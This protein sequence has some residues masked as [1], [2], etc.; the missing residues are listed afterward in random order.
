[1]AYRD[2]VRGGSGRGPDGICVLQPAATK[3]YWSAGWKGMNIF[4]P[5]PCPDGK[6]GF[7]PARQSTTPNDFSDFAIAAETVVFTGQH[8]KLTFISEW[9]GMSDADESPAMRLYRTI[10]NAW[11]TGA[12]PQWKPF[13][14]GRTA[15]ISKPGICLFM[16]G[17]LKTHNGK[18]VNKDDIVFMLK[19]SGR[20]ALESM[21]STPNPEYKHPGDASAIDM[22][23]YF[24]CPDPTDL[25]NGGCIFIE[26]KESTKERNAHYAVG[27]GMA[28]PVTADKVL[29]EWAPWD[30]LLKYQTPEEQIKL[31][32]SCDLN[33][34]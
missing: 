8:R 30:Q 11:E 29:K 7:L 9:K 16:Q 28:M 26:P 14:Y 1:M 10:H 34:L 27:L 25:A 12:F 19:Q 4:R 15:F 18:E 22:S 3:N 13:V 23:K 20:W 17:H 33:H 21:L 32:I 5:Y 2:S 24:N 6:G 31:F